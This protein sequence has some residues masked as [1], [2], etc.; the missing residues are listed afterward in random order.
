MTAILYALGA[1]AAAV[2]VIGMAAWAFI[3]LSDGGDR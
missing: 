2:L 1:I 3:R